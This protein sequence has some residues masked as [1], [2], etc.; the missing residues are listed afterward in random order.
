M[1]AASCGPNGGGLSIPPAGGTRVPD[2]DPRPNFI[3]EAPGV[4]LRGLSREEKGVFFTILN[5]ETS[6]CNQPHSL[7]QSLRD[8]PSC[9]D[10]QIVAQFVA[11]AIEAGAAAADIRHDIPVV[12]KALT[13][14][15]IDIGGRPVYGPEH[16]PVTVVVFADFQ[17]PHCRLEAPKLRAA[18]DAAEGQ[19]KLVFK[20]FP[21]GHHQVAKRAA[22]ATE[23]AHRAGKFWAMHD[24]IFAHQGELTE[25]L[26]A[27][28]AAQIGLD[29]AKF[30]TDLDADVGIEA[31]EADHAEGQRL[32]I[33]GTPAVFIDGR[34]FNA[35]LL[36]GTLE[37]WIEDARA[38]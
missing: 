12:A 34:Q 13:P 3:H 1:G 28:L 30:A 2:A 25:A 10:S 21:L 27:E 17:C 19:A 32:G 37:A 22:V 6:A 36:G 16:A 7:A 18:I 23:V 4:A 38:R 31:V 9:R 24:Q 15:P 8:D 29:A 11:D 35:V 20:H 5:T 26:L 14:Q 33:A